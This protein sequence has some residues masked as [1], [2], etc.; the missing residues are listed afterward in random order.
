MEYKTPLIWEG[1]VLK[2]IQT[3]LGVEKIPNFRVSASTG[4]RGV[5]DL[6]VCYKGSFVGF[7]VKRPHNKGVASPNQIQVGEQIVESGG[8]FFIVSSVDEVER[9][10]AVVDCLNGRGGMKCEIEI[11][12]GF[13]YPQVAA[14][15]Q[16]AGVSNVRE[17]V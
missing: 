7:E 9:A 8:Y 13:T 5:P 4:R 14:L 6:F 3:F 1:D 15:K 10:F 17:E 16:I 11:L 12:K 2:K